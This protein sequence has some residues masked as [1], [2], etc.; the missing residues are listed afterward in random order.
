MIRILLAALAVVF[1]V[2][3]VQAAGVNGP[4]VEEVSHEPANPSP[5]QDVVVT[6]HLA[7]EADVSSILLTHC[8][9]EP[10]YACSVK[11]DSMTQAA[12]G[13]WTGLVPWQVGFF[14]GTRWVGYNLL[15]QTGDGNESKAP[16][17]DVP[18]TPAGLP[19]DAGHYYFYEIDAQ[20]ADT[21]GLGPLALLVVFVV[22]GML[23]RRHVA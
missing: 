6:V 5:G 7:P 14:D 11:T 17:E 13:S 2:P 21:P 23:R 8:R 15:I 9:V 3:V 16:L 10:S 12:D 19:E 1:L 22:G 18:A 4:L 20:R